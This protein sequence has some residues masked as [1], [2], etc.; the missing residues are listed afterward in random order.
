M[1]HWNL[2]IHVSRSYL[3]RSLNPTPRK[4]SRHVRSRERRASKQIL[5][6]TSYWSKERDGMRRH[7]PST[8]NK[9]GGRRSMQSVHF[10]THYTRGS[11]A[12]CRATNGDWFHY[13]SLWSNRVVCCTAQHSLR[14]V[15]MMSAK[16]A[17][18]PSLPP[19][20]TVSEPL[21]MSTGPSS[22]INIYQSVC[23]TGVFW[24]GAYCTLPLTPAPIQL[25]PLHIPQHM[26]PALIQIACLSRR[27]E[28]CPCCFQMGRRKYWHISVRGKI[29]TKMWNICK[30]V[31]ELNFNT[32]QFMLIGI[33][34]AQFL[35][36]G[37]T[38]PF[39]VSWISYLFFFASC[40]G[41]QAKF[42]AL[43]S[44]AK[45]LGR[46][47]HRRASEQMS[48][49]INW[50]RK[51]FPGTCSSRPGRRHHQTR[52]SGKHVWLTVTDRWESD[53]M[54][55]RP[56]FVEVSFFAR[57]GSKLHQWHNMMIKRMEGG[58]KLSGLVRVARQ[59][60]LTR[61]CFDKQQSRTF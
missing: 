13:V 12:C 50:S 4:Q 17:A 27:W 22:I 20:V 19:A 42:Q 29:F 9:S 7:V 46:K 10:Q 30:M 11:G 59:Q 53:G 47:W 18:F 54:M 8:I 35:D 26:E 32:D 37:A 16:S 33:R 61:K 48:A 14:S 60:F 3:R 39:P 34:P 51:S 43:C 2:F 36:F 6:L 52:L 45:C 57:G 49:R 1:F 44:C 23:A 15:R 41:C 31:F 40:K 38:P 28:R 5:F 21:A 58:K 55:R 24:G 56:V 25:I